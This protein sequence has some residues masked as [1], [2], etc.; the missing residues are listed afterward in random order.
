M[1]GGAGM[2][3]MS[4]YYG[5]MP[6]MGPLSGL[7]QFLF[8][9]QNVVFS[10]SQAVQILGMNTQALQQLLDTAT[11]MLEQA[12]AAYKEMRALEMMANDSESEEAKKKR[13]RLKAL[14]WAL[15]LAVTYGG[16]RVV[17]VAFQQKRRSSRRS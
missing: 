8:G 3:G 17:R 9:V 15:V 4:P 2:Y 16:Y 5:G 6:Q 13:R 7:N 1:Y 12:L 10:L 14:R 11:T